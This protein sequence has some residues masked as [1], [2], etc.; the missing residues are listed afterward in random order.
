MTISSRLSHYL[1]QRGADFDICAHPHS[2]TSVQ[3]ARVAHVPAHELAKPVIVEDDAGCVMA[4]VPS[5]RRVQLGQ[6]A[7][8]LGRKHLHL[9]DED[10]IAELFTD[11][12]RGAVPGLGMAWGVETVVDEQLEATEYVYVEGGDHQCL[13]RMSHAQ[14]HELV[15]T[16][17]HGQFCAV[18]TH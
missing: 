9:A 16:L 13:L 6:L 11:C 5:D 3:T 4:V 14:F 15:R 7:R 1:D 10:R 17:R 2:Q 12:D 8:L 18:P